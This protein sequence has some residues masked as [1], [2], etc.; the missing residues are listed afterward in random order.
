MAALVDHITAGTMST[1]IK[2]RRATKDDMKSVSDLTIAVGWNFTESLVDTV[3]QSSR[4]GIFVAEKGTILVNNITE[5]LAHIGLSITKEGHRKKGLQTT[6]FKKYSSCS[7]E[8]NLC[9]VAGSRLLASRY[10]NKFDY[11]HIDSEV[12]VMEGN[13]DHSILKTKCTAEEFDILPVNAIPFDSL[14][15]YDEQVCS[16][17]RPHF[18]KY[19][20]FGDNV[21][22]FVAVK[23]TEKGSP[24]I[25]GCIVVWPI[26]KQFKIMPLYA[27]SSIVAK[28]LI[29]HVLKMLS[30]GATIS[31]EIPSPNTT[32][33]EMG[34]SYN[35]V[36]K[37]TFV[38]QYTK[39]TIPLQIGKVFSA[40]SGGIAPV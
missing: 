27:D 26:Y 8:R 10:S 21:Y 7:D 6:M 15:K 5:N 3:R 22:T 13:V 35:L 30:D 11:I 16:F 36:E 19:W 29:D 2:F 34:K 1:E 12:K 14:V 40:C 4:N 28:S 32:A 24:I 18:L 38:R 23:C 9:L 39:Q 17:A 25:L 31:L 20:C 33:L 37:H